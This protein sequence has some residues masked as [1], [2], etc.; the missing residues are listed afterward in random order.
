MI[1]TYAGAEYHALG[2]SVVLARAHTCPRLIV[3]FITTMD[4]GA[5]A[6]LAHTVTPGICKV[7]L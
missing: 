1:C 2:L 6:L 7:A 3:S 5:F 4:N